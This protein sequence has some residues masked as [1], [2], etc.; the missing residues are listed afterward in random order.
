MTLQMFMVL[1]VAVIVYFGF[2]RER[3]TGSYGILDNCRARP[4]GKYQSKANACER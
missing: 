4:A 2:V 1:S 3:L